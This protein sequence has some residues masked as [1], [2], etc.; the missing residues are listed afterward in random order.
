MPQTVITLATRG[1]GLYEFTDQAAQFTRTAA[2]GGEGLL[3]V[4][5][6]HT[7]CS[8]LIQENADPDVKTDL[9]AFFRR[10]VPPSS[11]PS[12]RWIVHTTEGPDDM[13]AH[14]KAALTQVSI[15]IPVM[16]GRLVLGTWQ[17]IYLFE[18]RDRPHRR[19]IVLHLST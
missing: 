3:T 5:V 15:G 4:F 14:I 2:G 11:D 17:G 9:N 10:L 12:M 16:A 18:H 19:E 8:L 7:S 6:R 13:P 1:Q